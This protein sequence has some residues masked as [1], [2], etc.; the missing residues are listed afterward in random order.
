MKSNI[1]RRIQIALATVF[2]IL[3]L[4]GGLRCLLQVE[5]CFASEDS[6]YNIESYY[7]CGNTLNNSC[8]INCYDIEEI[9]GLGCETDHCGFGREAGYSDT[10][11][12][13]GCRNW[14]LLPLYNPFYQ[15]CID[16]DSMSI[17]SEADQEIFL[18]RIRE[19]IN[20]WNSVVMH[21][22]SGQLVQ[23]IETT[24]DA[25]NLAGTNVCPIKYEPNL[26]ANVAGRFNPVPL[27]HQI[28]IKNFSSERTI[29]HEL[30]HLLG[31]QDLDMNHE[32]K[33]HMVLMGYKYSTPYI[34]YQDIQGIAVANHK[35]TQHDF[36]RYAKIN[37]KY[38]HVCF[39]CDIQTTL[40]D[41]LAGSIP[42]VEAATCIHN[43]QPMVSAGERHWLKCTKCYKVIES[44]Y[45]V[46][47][48]KNDGVSS[49]EI[50][51]LINSN[52]SEITIPRQI[53]DLNVVGI[54]DNAFYGNVN[55]T[56]VIFETR[57]NV[58]Q[59]GKN[60]FAGCNNIVKID[61]P[62]SVIKIDE[63]AFYNCNNMINVTMYN[64]LAEIGANAFANCFNLSAIYLPSSVQCLGDGVFKDCRT[65]SYIYIPQSVSYIGTSI[66]VGCN[67]LN[68]TMSTANTNYCIQDN[69]VYNYDKTIV[70]SAANVPTKLILPESV[71]VVE[72][73]A[74]ERN[75][76][77]TEVVFF[78]NPEIGAKAFDSCEN[79]AEVFFYP[80][81]PPLLDTDSF[82][83]ND[84]ILYVPCIA[85]ESYERSFSIYTD[86]ITS[87]QF[88]LYFQ[89][90]DII[91]DSEVHYFG[92]IIQDLSVP[93]KRGHSFVAWYKKLTN[94]KIITGDLWLETEDL[95]VYAKW[96]ANNYNLLF[97]MTDCEK[98]VVTFG[99]PVG[100]LPV[101][102]KEGYS[103]DGWTTSSGEK[104]TV[105]TVYNF[106]YSTVLVPNWKANKYNIIFDG[107][108]GITTDEKQTVYFDDV[109]ETLTGGVLT[110]YTFEGWN[111]AK[112]GSG[113]IFATPFIYDY[114]QD[115]KL[116]AQWK[117][118]V[119]T[120]TY[121]LDGGIETDDNPSTY[122]IKDCINFVA[123]QKVGYTFMEWQL[124]GKAINGIEV[125][126]YGDLSI[127][128]IWQANTYNVTLDA[129]GGTIDKLTFNVV[130]DQPFKVPTV[131]TRG[132]YVLDKWDDENGHK[133]AK[134]DG[135]GT[136]NWDK[137]YN[138]ILTAQWSVKS[139][140][141]QINDNG[142]IIWLG[143]NGLSETKCNIEYGTVMNA[144]N[145]IKIFK[146]SD[147][148]FKEGKIF[149][150]FEYED[151]TLSWSSI[152]D[153]GE[154]GKV[155]TIIPVWILEQ[156][157]IYFNTLS[158]ITV[159][160]LVANFDETIVLPSNIE[161]TGYTFDGWFTAAT[162]GT[163][164]IWT[165]MPD[166]TPNE[167]SNGSTVLYA[168]YIPIVYK[169]NYHLDGGTNASS[170]PLEYTIKSYYT[171]EA[172]IKLGYE[173]SGW[174]IDAAKTKQ[175]VAL[176]KSHDIY[177]LY[178]KWVPITYEIRYNPTYGQ[179]KMPNSQHTYDVPK[180]LSPNTFTNT[181][182]TFFGWTKS[183]TGGPVYY[184]SARIV[185]WSTVKDSVIDIYAAW[186]AN[187][188]HIAYDANGGTGSMDSDSLRYNH[189]QSLS[190]CTFSRTGYLFAGWSTTPNGNIVYSDQASVENLTAMPDATVTL[191]AQWKNKTYFVDL[192]QQGGTGG[193]K[194]I[195]ATY[196]RAMPTTNKPSRTG[197]TFQGYYTLENGNGIKYYNNNMSSANI[198]LQ[199][200]NNV[201]L[202][203]YWTANKY[204][205]TFNKEGGSGGSTTVVAT[206]GEEMPAASRPG[207]A[208]FT[209]GGYYYEGTR[210]YTKTM[211]R[212]HVWDIAANVTL[213]AHWSPITTSFGVHFI[214]G[215]LTN[216]SDDY[217]FLLSSQKKSVQQ[218]YPTSITAPDIEG[219][220]FQH[221]LI[222][223]GYPKQTPH[224]ETYTKNQT[225]GISYEYLT[226]EM[227]KYR[228]IDFYAVY[229][230]NT[231]IATG[232]LITLAD[233]RQIPV[234]ELTGNEMLLVWNMYTG[235]YGAS[236]ILF[237]DKENTQVYKAINLNFSD[238]TTV[239]VISEHGFWDYDLNKYV[240]LDSNASQ[241]IGHWFNKG[242][243]RV[244]LTS[245]DIRDE[246]TT[247]YSPVTEGHLCYFVNGMLSMPG[248]ISGLFNIFEVDPDAMTYN[249]Q[250]MAHDIE[251]YGLFTYE[252]F[253]EILPVPES[254]FYAFNGQYLKVAIGKD[255]I[256]FD[257]LAILI[258][259]YAIFFD[260][261]N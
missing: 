72:K 62:T 165:S 148:G 179:G 117:I 80:L 172:P 58:L 204:T 159:D 256:T 220:T 199:D 190:K 164:F 258:Q 22:G 36:Q 248:G 46:K 122:T 255:L 134:P 145:L 208:Y 65:L 29:K 155:V 49:L 203:A 26:P 77:V 152:P 101:P 200:N 21:D 59:I 115:I 198:W 18:A 83:N 260:S 230:E 69:V 27:L 243:T 141:I 2:V 93:T 245:V 197:Y 234:E 218:G 91:V 143:A 125:G 127:I 231:C 211:E 14:Q 133:Y 97:D 166:L 103:F 82:S 61:L 174:F 137:P 140:E 196:N 178:A 257:Q 12:S 153:L 9:D 139:Y 13:K 30:G 120:I 194:Y 112:D 126:N 129:N 41:P 168:Q 114:G 34:H 135:E 63:R 241:Y 96:E 171:L 177:D 246:Y 175:I 102:E 11:F 219:Y 128:A 223:G 85:Q 57:S 70:I 39:Y 193:D 50:T 55:L 99:Q 254:V 87:P 4:I 110:G 138:A 249:A 251:T 149:D 210:Y 229:K 201:T 100:E 214:S 24:T 185:N 167:Q 45:Y 78:S 84:F 180:S 116:Y 90:D 25:T 207:R 106:D 37:G 113:K 186:I 123:P 98:Q 1:K 68:I 40:L 240:Y 74:F 111:T 157:T 38:T 216:N 47:G 107:N 54:A 154:N 192:D 151:E 237:V 170:N 195:I 130:Y 92:S 94:E 160:E 183:P 228:N 184:D 16:T 15:Y 162:N 225:A 242:D 252:E 156:H 176:S 212:S 19:A 51:G 205:I 23:L 8:N 189:S 239:K 76:N 244:Q 144:I 60:A 95:F 71:S 215:K 28:E 182:Y 161:R 142:S 233:G 81:T 43:F 121:V 191:Y 10:Y 119:Y 150:H 44:D 261:M 5:Q 105:E 6:N 202:Y 35:H 238:G 222:R 236:R 206:F 33:E 213:S 217:T 146:E 235:T 224:I 64:G 108:G 136:R 89:S 163:K 7:N 259:R 132:G 188:Y 86:I 221:W 124:D 53:G 56:E 66:F 209:F 79:L 75:T 169:I 187:N 250:S 227:S 158:D 181:G 147:A 52:E 226:T 88:T 42:F 3:L 247:A 48:I 73:C 173:F 32:E 118:N 232:T 104:I 17:L 31:L 20:D 67:N 131:P 253:A 109:V